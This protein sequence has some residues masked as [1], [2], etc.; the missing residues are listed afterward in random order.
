MNNNSIKLI[1]GAL[2][3]GLGIAVIFCGITEYK[4]EYNKC[5]RILADEDEI[6][7]GCDKYF[8]YGTNK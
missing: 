5:V 2:L 8:L 6:A 1:F 7:N 3:I 4:G